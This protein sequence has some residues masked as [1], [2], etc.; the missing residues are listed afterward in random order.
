MTTDICAVEDD[1]DASPG[2]LSVFVRDRSIRSLHAPRRMG[3]QRLA[4]S[5]RDA[6]VSEGI[7]VSFY[8]DTSGEMVIAFD[9]VSVPDR[10]VVRVAYL[11]HQTVAA[12]RDRKR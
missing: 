9:R 3:T 7:S 1:R 5:V 6:A 10:D 4:E 11:C 12:Y 8:P 2:N